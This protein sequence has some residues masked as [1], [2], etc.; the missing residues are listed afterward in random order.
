MRRRG[1][2]G[3][4]V[5]PRQKAERKI[6]FKR[7]ILGEGRA[8]LPHFPELQ[9][10]QVVRARPYW[11]CKSESWS[12]V[13]PSTLSANVKS[14]L[15]LPRL[16]FRFLFLRVIILS[17]FRL[18]YTGIAASLFLYSLS[19]SLC[20]LLF[21]FLFLFFYIVPRPFSLTLSLSRRRLGVPPA[22][23][24]ALLISVLMS[25]HSLAIVWR[26][27]RHNAAHNGGLLINHEAIG[28][29]RCPS[30]SV[31]VALAGSECH[32]MPGSDVTLEGRL[33]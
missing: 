10:N 26:A 21:P 25:F 12:L 9:P 28:S 8:G 16:H 15:I 23:S 30:P 32:V 3:G 17:Y 2:G 29:G 24:F 22:A 7:N 19:V 11:F 13:P 18:R 31:A 33:T 1:G 14:G 4:C 6:N 5:H 27:H 20:N